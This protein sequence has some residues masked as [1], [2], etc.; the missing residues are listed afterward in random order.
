MF[1]DLPMSGANFL[2]GERVNIGDKDQL[3]LWVNILHLLSTGCHYRSRQQRGRMMTDLIER[4]RDEPYW[5]AIRSHGLNEEECKVWHRACC[6]AANEIER[7][8]EVIKDLR[9]ALEDRCTCSQYGVMTLCPSCETLK[10]YDAQQE[11]K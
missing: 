1:L 5:D 3:G 4:L 9:G 10:D 2:G 7:L 11:D 6:E 8:H